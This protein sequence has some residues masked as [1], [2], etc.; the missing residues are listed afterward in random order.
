M[1]LHVG[2]WHSCSIAIKYA[3]ISLQ[4][5]L[6]F[7]IVDGHL[8]VYIFYV[9]TVSFAM[10]LFHCFPHFS[11]ELFAFFFLILR[12]VYILNITLLL[13]VCRANVYFQFVFCL[14]TLFMVFLI[15]LFIYNLFF[16]PCLK[17]HAL[18]QSIRSITHTLVL[19]S[20]HLQYCLRYL[21]L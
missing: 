3:I 20:K 21:G 18:F 7:T 8:V 2:V 10:R 15:R 19:F 14:F 16:L 9:I 11:I 6:Y 17:D 13:V 12:H 4:V 5:L 1:C